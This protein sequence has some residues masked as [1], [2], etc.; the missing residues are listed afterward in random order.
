MFVQTGPGQEKVV[1][2]KFERRLMLVVCPEQSE[3]G[4][5]GFDEAVG[6]GSTVTIRFLVTPMHPLSVGVI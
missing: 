3:V 1:V 5:T 2:T 4:L 6:S